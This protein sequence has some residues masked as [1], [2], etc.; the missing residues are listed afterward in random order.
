MID[1]MNVRSDQDATVWM[2]R[3]GSA[4]IDIPTL[5]E[6][7]LAPFESITPPTS[8]SLLTRQFTINQ[9]DVVTWVV[10]GY[11]YREPQTP[12]LFGNTSDGWDANTTLKFPLNSTID[13]ILRI[14]N[15]SM[16][17]VRLSPCCSSMCLG[18][19]QG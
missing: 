2:L 14:A 18:A 15:D 1:P 11:P 3:N 9:T 10:D 8:P 4:K 6:R 19:V 16:D 12:I 5:D 17:T 7:S 13:L